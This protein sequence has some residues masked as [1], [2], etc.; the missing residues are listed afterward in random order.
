MMNI[1]AEGLL[2]HSFVI[3]IDNARFQSF[4]DR[5]RLFNLKATPRKYDGLCVSKFGEYLGSSIVNGSILCSLSHRSVVAMAKSLDLP[6][7]CIFEDDACPSKQMASC[8]EYYLSAIPN[9]IDVL[10]LGWTVRLNDDYT[11]F[12][13]TL[14]KNF[15]TYGAH[16]YVVFKRYYN[17]YLQKSKI[18]PASDG[19]LINGHDVSAYTTIKNIFIQHNSIDTCLHNAKNS[20]FNARNGIDESKYILRA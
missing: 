18:D 12:S 8:I 14:Y 11:V 5:M 7:V 2:K 13:K 4:I 3:T 17:R 19:D 1:S 16:A 10:K 9:S 20:Q 6:Y 15:R